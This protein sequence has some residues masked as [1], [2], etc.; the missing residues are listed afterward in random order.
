MKKLIDYDWMTGIETW[1]HYDAE[2]DRTTIESVQDVSAILELNKARQNE[3]DGGYATK[4]RDWRRV[5][6]IPNVV[7]EKW[8]R[9][10]R[11]DVFNKDHWPAVRRKLNSSEYLYLRTALWNV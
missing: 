5:A 8:L 7:I 4:D 3:G 9:E 1:H 2:T 11:I 10:D 6:S